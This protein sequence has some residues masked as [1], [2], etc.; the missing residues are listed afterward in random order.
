MI[1]KNV[2]MVAALD[3]PGRGAVPGFCATSTQ[4][5]AELLRALVSWGAV[6]G[7]AVLRRTQLPASVIGPGWSVW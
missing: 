5:A 6:L 7:Q 1:G 2:V 4:A 3:A